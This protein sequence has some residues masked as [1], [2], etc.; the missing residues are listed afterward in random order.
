[1]RCAN[2]HGACQARRKARCGRSERRDAAGSR[3]AD[4]GVRSPIRQGLCAARAVSPLRSRLRGAAAA[5]GGGWA[6][7]AAKASEFR[8]PASVPVANP[9]VALASGA[10]GC[11]GRM[12][13]FIFSSRVVRF[14]PSSCAA[15]FL[16]P[17]V[18]RAPRGSAAPRR[19][20]TTSRK[21][22]PVAGT[23]SGRQHRRRCCGRRSPA[24]RRA[25]ISRSPPQH[26]HALD[27][28][29]ELAHV[30][31]PVVRRTSALERLARD[32]SD[33][34]SACGPGSAR[35]RKCWTSSGMSS[36]RS[37]SGGTSI[38]ITFRR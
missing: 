16:L 33:L 19:S 30:A 26:H 29:L 11:G 7:P 5:T 18:A 37:R 34:A 12:R 28:V 17:C 21:L 1:M 14:S 36:R 2:K 25:S 27:Q 6:R 32:R 3:G 23:R 31:G 38:G 4:G 35:S 9:S 15:R 8:R 24:D 20:S 10:A 13:R 22:R